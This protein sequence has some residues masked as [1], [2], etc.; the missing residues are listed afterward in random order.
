MAATT[1]IREF[2]FSLLAEYGSG[3]LDR[4][5]KVWATLRRMVGN[6][7]E[8]VRPL[9]KELIAF[10]ASKLKRGATVVRETTQKAGSALLRMAEGFLGKRRD[11]EAEMDPQPEPKPTEK[12]GAETAKKE[13][14]SQRCA[15]APQAVS[16]A[17]AESS[18][19]AREAIL[20][21]G[22]PSGSPVDALSTF[23][24]VVGRALIRALSRPRPARPLSSTSDL[25]F[26]PILAARSSE[27]ARGQSNPS[28]LPRH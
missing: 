19:V 2:V 8:L 25:G 12:R 24:P 17:P 11:P 9:L 15:A 6:L 5:R 16:A 3:A 27:P 26:G 7:R 21:K 22:E 23:G 1:G 10:F 18:G 4:V 20:A 28:S 13:A 14:V